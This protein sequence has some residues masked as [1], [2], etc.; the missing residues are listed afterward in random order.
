MN[1]ASE[2][3]IP[4]L[5]RVTGIEPALS[6]WEAGDAPWPGTPV[7]GCDQEIQ[8]LQLHLAA[9]LGRKLGRNSPLPGICGDWCS[10]VPFHALQHPDTR[11]PGG[12]SHGC[13][14]HCRYSEYM[15]VM[16]S[17][18]QPLSA[19]PT[20]RHVSID[21]DADLCRP[22]AHAAARCDSS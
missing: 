12:S 7:I 15:A 10:V 2:L 5:E 9:C 14:L 22:Q 16:K 1:R 8:P 3:R 19:L 20:V 21:V 6:A 18:C 11:T 17:D 13:S 4:A